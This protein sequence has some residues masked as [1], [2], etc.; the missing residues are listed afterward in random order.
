M[1]NFPNSLIAKVKD[2]DVR[3]VLNELIRRA[4]DKEEVEELIKKKGK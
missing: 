4:T 1:K 2:P 3:Q